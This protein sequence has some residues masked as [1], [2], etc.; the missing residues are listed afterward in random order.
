MAQAA[1][2]TSHQNFVQEALDNFA[3]LLDDTDFTAHLHLMGVGRLH[4]TRRKQLL[5]EWRGLYV[6]LW[7]LA[8]GRSFPQ[9]AD[10]MLEAFRRSYRERHRDKQTPQM[11]ERAEQYWDMMRVTRESDFTEVARHF[12]SLCQLN[13]KDARSLQ[14]KLALIIRK[15]YTDIFRRLI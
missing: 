7:R 1:D 2:V 13:E 6:A 3:V 10:A 11:L 4:F 8:L 5:Q 14:L 9:D 15:A 12:C